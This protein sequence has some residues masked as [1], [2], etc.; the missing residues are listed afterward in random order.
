MLIDPSV[1]PRDYDVC[2]CGYHV[3]RETGPCAPVEIEPL[4]MGPVLRALHEQ[5][6]ESHR[7]AVDQLAAAAGIPSHLLR[8][9]PPVEHAPADDGL[10]RRGDQVRVLAGHGSTLDVTGKVGVVRDATPTY[11]PIVGFPGMPDGWFLADELEHVK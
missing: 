11:T 7:K 2:K 8:G 3:C 4:I 6:A 1:A 9:N 10:F 5:F